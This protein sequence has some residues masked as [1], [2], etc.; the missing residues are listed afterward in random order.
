MELEIGRFSRKCKALQRPLQAGEW[1]YCVIREDGE[2]LIREDYSA[3]AWTKPPE[4]AVAVWKHR[5][6]P[7]GPKRWKLA[8][9]ATLLAMLLNLADQPHQQR[10]RY[11]LA[12]MLLRRRVVRAREDRASHEDPGLLA[13]ESMVDGTAIDVMRCELD[14]AAEQQLQQQLVDLV[15]CEAA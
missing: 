4:D 6:P 7:A 14:S 10:T 11:L 8:P 12:L 3:A 1:Y 2:Q 15:Y 5:M 9:D 13:L